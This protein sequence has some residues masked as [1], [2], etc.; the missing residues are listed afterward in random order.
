MPAAVLSLAETIPTRAAIRRTGLS[1]A[2]DT[3]VTGLRHDLAGMHRAARR[4][5]ASAESA[6]PHQPSASRYRNACHARTPAD[7]TTGIRPIRS[8]LGHHRPRR[9]THGARRAPLQ[10]SR[11]LG[12]TNGV[13][14]F[15][16]PFVV[17]RWGSERRVEAGRHRQGRCRLAPIPDL[18]M[19]PDARRSHRSRCAHRKRRAV[20][21]KG[22]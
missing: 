1:S 9:Q 10:S 2:N 6:E 4:K 3:S 19:V 21:Q 13:I 11:S 12:I 15:S 5:A 17:A 18:A 20:T 16:S 14:G 22:L 8:N 7:R